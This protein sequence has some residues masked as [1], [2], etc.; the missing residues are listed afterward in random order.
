MA[1]RPEIYRSK[2]EQ[3]ERLAQTTLDRDG[4]RRLLET[5]MWWRNMAEEAEKHPPDAPSRLIPAAARGL[6]D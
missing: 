2:A 4:R 3:C 6:D 1:A 5:A